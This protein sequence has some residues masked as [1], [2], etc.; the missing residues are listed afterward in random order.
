[1]S[2][3]MLPKIRQLRTTRQ[4]TQSHGE[5]VQV[6][7]TGKRK[8][9]LFRLITNG[10][11]L[12]LAPIP[13]LLLRLLVSIGIFFIGLPKIAL[14][15]LRG[16]LVRPLTYRWISLEIRLLT[17]GPL[18]RDRLEKRPFSQIGPV[19]QVNAVRVYRSPSC[20]C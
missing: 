15:A 10:S 1:M 3:R 6:S 13:S 14:I 7:L 5:K 9:T 18:V 16:R 17:N 11:L 19:T 2:L 4:Q 8:V 20:F 12:V